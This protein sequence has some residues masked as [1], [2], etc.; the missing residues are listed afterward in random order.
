MARARLRDRHQENLKKKL[1]ILMAEQGVAK[2][3]NESPEKQPNN[4][5]SES[6]QITEENNPCTSTAPAKSDESQSE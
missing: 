1:N 2:T 5:E 3:E 6:T 4:E